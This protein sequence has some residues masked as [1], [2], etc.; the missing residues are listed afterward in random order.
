MVRQ[1]MCS[2]S[3]PQPKQPNTDTEIDTQLSGFSGCA[4]D[5]SPEMHEPLITVT[6]ISRVPF[7]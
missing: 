5:T 7:Q 1:C 4:E 6:L 2:W 3:V